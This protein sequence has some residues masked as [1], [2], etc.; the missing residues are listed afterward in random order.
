VLERYSVSR[1]VN[2]VDRLYRALLGAKGMGSG[3][4]I[5]HPGMRD[6]KT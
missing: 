5:T 3:L 2:D 4:A 1:L 6:C